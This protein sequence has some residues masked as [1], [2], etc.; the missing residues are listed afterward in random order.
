MNKK[1]T[2]A[3]LLTLVMSMALLLSACGG[4]TGGDTGNAGGGSGD[5]QTEGEDTGGN[6]NASGGTVK[7][8]CGYGV[9]GTADA[10][11]RKYALVANRLHSD[12][13]FIVEN[14]TGG[15]GF[16]AAD[17]YTDLDP[18]THELLIYGYGL[19]Y[20]HDLGKNYGT[21]VVDFDRADI[22][23]IGCIDDRTWILYA[24]PGTSLADI[25]AKSKEGGIKMSG[26]NPL[27]DPHLALGSL[28]ALEGGKL[29][30]VPYDGGAAQKKGLTDGEVDVFVGTTQAAQD[31]VEAGTLIP[32]L[33]FSDQPFNGFTGP[34]GEISVPTIA[35]DTKDPAL[36]AS[37]D[38]TGS[39]LKSGGFIATRTGA[40]QAWVDE[41]T[42]ITKDVWADAEFSDWMA[43]ILLNKHE[44][45]GADAV[46]ELE[47]ASQ[48]AM[49]AFET[50]SGNT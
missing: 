31:E 17:Y 8:V 32:I 3:L 29:M 30:V 23:P 25:L 35:G 14:M 33:A 24:A 50:L 15:D 41:L 1:R 27:S 11:A 22:Q 26:G 12:Y 20:R 2:L 4:N 45:Y 38:Y 43:S 13:N 6:P 19:I 16:A 47:E 44:V 37:K 21:E 34:D 28:I 10:I 40:D 49:A 9:G 7:I 48:K 39:I 18:S 46:A 42:Q 5:A 36:D